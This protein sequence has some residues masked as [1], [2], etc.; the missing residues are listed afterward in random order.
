MENRKDRK[1]QQMKQQN[2]RSIWFIGTSALL[3]TMFAIA[4]VMSGCSKTNDNPAAEKTFITLK[5][6]D[7]MVHLA[8]TWAEVFMKENPG[9]EVSVT[10]G[11]SGTGIAA[12]LNGTTDIC[13]ASRKIKDKETSMAAQK[14]IVPKE[15]VVARD[16]IAVIVNPA[17]PVSELTI[18][19]IGKIFTG[20]VRRWDQVGGK[21]ESIEIL[22]RDSSS[23][24]YVFFQEKVLRKKD[25]SQNAKLMPATSA[26]VQSVASNKSAIGYVGLGYAVAA[27]NK[28]KVLAVRADDNSPAVIPSER[29][30]KSGEY[31]IARPLH[32]YTNGQATGAVKKFIDFCLSSKGQEIV[33]QTGYV[34]IQ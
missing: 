26:I 2:E 27:K 6:S 23:G 9:L 1:V 32:L 29:T 18:E 22:S 28:I 25:Y 19:Q 4:V 7:T 3:L 14:G 21:A 20:A 16:G 30:V 13:A 8:S 24:T 12:L 11:G 34:A 15:I 33:R 17:N 5:G 31:K 10:G